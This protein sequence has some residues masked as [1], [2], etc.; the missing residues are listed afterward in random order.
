MR[1]SRRRNSGFPPLWENV[2]MASK[3]IFKRLRERELGLLLEGAD[4]LSFSAGTTVFSEGDPADAAYIVDSGSI[5]LSIDK[6][7]QIEEVA[8]LGSGEFFGEMAIFK[9]DVRAVTATAQSDCVLWRVGSAN[10]KRL[11]DSDPALAEKVTALL[12][13]RQ[14]EL[15]LKERLVSTTGV[16][17]GG[18]H[19]SIKGDPSLRETAFT[20]ERYTSIVDKVLPTLLPA[21]RHLLLDTAVYRVFVGLNNGEVRVYSVMSPFT[22]ELHTAGKIVSEA[23]MERHFPPMNYQAKS[24]FIL[25]MLNHIGNSN[26]FRQMPDEWRILMQEQTLQ[27]RPVPRERL[28]TVIDHLLDMRRMPNVYLRNFGIS[29]VQDAV[30]LQ[31]NCDGTHIVSTAEYQKFLE[32]NISSE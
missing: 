29:M 30:R 14:I 6:Q 26:A 10:L 27:W 18:L 1:L 17:G 16:A 24:T 2:P 13:S 7:G 23:Y 28:E 8:A 19:V 4:R 22:E 11:I 15:F 3:N 20:R 31:F 32:E 12:Q 5:V 9:N 21:L 25:E